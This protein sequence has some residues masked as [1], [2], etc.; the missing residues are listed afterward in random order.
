MVVAGSIPSP[1]TIPSM[2][3]RKRSRNGSAIDS[4]R[5]IRAGHEQVWPALVNLRARR[6]PAARSRSASSW[7][8]K[9]ACPPSSMVIPFMSAPACPPR[10]RPTADE[11]VKVTCRIAGCSRRVRQLS[12]ERVVVMTFITPGGRPAASKSRA[13]ARALNGVSRCGLTTRGQPA[14]RAGAPL[15]VIIAKG[16]L[17][18]LTSRVGPAGSRKTS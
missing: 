14:A 10:C 16:S 12:F 3:A 6:S 11:P 7:T 9:G 5:N 15:R 8:T 2:P 13:A 1:T 4:W 17:P 18:E